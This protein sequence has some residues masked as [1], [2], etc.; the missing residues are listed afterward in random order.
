MWWSGQPD[1]EDSEGDEVLAHLQDDPPLCRAPKP[2]LYPAPGAFPILCP[3]FWSDG[4]IEGP[5]MVFLL[6]AW[7]E[8]GLI[9]LIVLITILVFSSLIFNFEQ[10]GLNPARWWEKTL[11]WYFSETL[12]NINALT[13]YHIIKGAEKCRWI[14]MHHS[15]DFMACTW[16]ALMT[17]TSVGSHLQPEVFRQ[18]FKNFHFL[19]FEVLSVKWAN[20]YSNDLPSIVLQYC[21]H[22]WLKPKLVR[23]WWASCS[24]GCAPSVGSSSSTSPPTSSSAGA[25]LELLCLNLV[26]DHL[27]PLTSFAVTYK[28]K[29]WR[30]E[31]ATK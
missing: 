16:W 18:I 26:L 4:S 24:A 27:C 21:S 23:L 12:W 9:L 10:D 20:K 11:K 15:R 6:Q 3:V 29:L 2:F 22:K 5:L 13:S 30:N 14:E 25:L 17:L 31:I 1:C 19:I 7:H 28:N 8:L